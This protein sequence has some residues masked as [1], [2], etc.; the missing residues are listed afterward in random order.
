SN[1][2]VAT[3]S[4]S[5]LVYGIAAGNTR[6]TYTSSITGCPTSFPDTVV[7][8]NSNGGGTISADQYYCGSY[9]PVR[10]NNV[11]SANPG[12][13]GA[14]VNAFWQ[15]ST[16]AINWV[17]APNGDNPAWYDPDP[18]STTTYYSRA[19]YSGDCSNFIV[20]SNIVAAYV[21]PVP[22]IS[23][24]TA[25][26]GPAGSTTQLTATGLPSLVNPWLSSSTSI[27]TVSSTGLVRN[28]FSGAVNI[29]YTDRGGCKDTVRVYFGTR[30][31]TPGTIGSSRN[32]CPG[33]SV[34][35]F[36]TVA[37]TGGTGSYYQWQRS[38]DNG[39][40]WT[41]IVG[42]NSSGYVPG[43]LTT[44]TWFRR[45]F[46]G[47][48]ACAPLLVSNVVQITVLVK[49]VI[50]GDSIICI[51]SGQ[52]TTQLSA[53]PG[54]I[55]WLSSNTT[56]FSVSSTGLVRRLTAS[57]ASATITAANTCNSSVITV[58]SVNPVINSL[59]SNVV[60][61]GKNV[62]LSASPAGGVWSSL[63]TTI[64]TV[65]S[66]G[67]VIGLKPG[68]ISVRY[69]FG[70]CFTSISLSVSQCIKPVF[71]KGT[72]ST[73]T[74]GVVL[75]NIASND[76]V[77]GVVATLGVSGNS[78]VSTVGVWPSGITLNTTTGAVSVSKGTT[79]GSYAVTYQLC[80]KLTPT[81]CSTMLD[82]VI[83]TPL[84]KPVFEKG[85]I[86]TSTGGVVL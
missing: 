29:I 34:T 11:V 41:D 75:S 65:S 53:S 85:T 73:S 67:V 42:A 24:V 55:T 45:L 68:N 79:P 28:V 43:I 70:S 54:T 66:N 36:E 22:N 80:D 33:T 78:V 84:V 13:G 57:N 4:S 62:A 72:I 50:T 15:I 5:G 40:T 3:V 21:T 10:L 20:Y 49:P 83:V 47:S 82:S 76:T 56:L 86:S 35:L 60:C 23:G 46:N 30:Y 59:P 63:D 32:I 58:Q 51:P 71:E 6:I 81:T 12:A 26:C 14:F 38:I 19:A 16:D 27:S 39:V 48:P 18:I 77:N 52:T 8:F 9:D 44:S 1:I 61:I 69:S 74:G 17:P 37:P 2:N 31:S 25:I 7:S 64:A